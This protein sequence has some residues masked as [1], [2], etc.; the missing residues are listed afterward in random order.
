MRAPEQPRGWPRATAPPLT[1]VIWCGSP[2][3][4]ITAS[5][6]TAKAS[7]SSI[8]RRSPIVSPARASALRT[9]GTGPRP[10]IRGGT[11]AAAEATTRAIG[12]RPRRAAKVSLANTSAAEPSFRPELL[13]AVTVPSLRKAGFNRASDSTVVS[14]RGRPSTAPRTGPPPRS[15]AGTG[16]DLERKATGVDSGHGAA[17]ALGGKLILLAAGDGAGHLI[18]IL[19]RLA[20]RL[21]AEGLVDLRVG[22]APPQGRVPSREVAQ[23]KNKPPIFS[24]PPP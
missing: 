24:R 16:G 7:L 6:C 19:G 5:D 9:A 1:L 10:I 22:G 12:R 8:R 17:M 4:R 11:P 23:T 18:D 2:S 3:S 13:P 15:R 21:G 20:H 14:R